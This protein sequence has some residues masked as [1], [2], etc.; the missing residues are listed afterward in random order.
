[1]ISFL[2]IQTFKNP[3]SSVNEITYIYMKCVGSAYFW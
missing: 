1:M 2:I 3:S